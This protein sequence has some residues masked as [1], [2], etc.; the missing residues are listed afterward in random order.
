MSDF[1]KW[2]TQYHTHTPDTFADLLLFQA[3]KEVAKEAWRVGYING[4]NRGPSGSRF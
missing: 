3:L 4:A 2:W 1:E